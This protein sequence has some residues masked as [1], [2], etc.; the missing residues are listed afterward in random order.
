MSSEADVA[1][2]R[3]RLESM[4]IQH[5]LLQQHNLKLESD[6]QAKQELDHKRFLIEAARKRKEDEENRKRGVE[7]KKKR[8]R[9][10]MNARKNA[11][12][13]EQRSPRYRPAHSNYVPSSKTGV[14]KTG[15]N[16]RVRYSNFPREQRFA[17]QRS[18]DTIP[19]PSDYNPN[20]SNPMEQYAYVDYVRPYANNEQLEAQREQQQKPG[21]LKIQDKKT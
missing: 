17:W 19:G 6:V 7:W 16:A 13:F 2:A 3:A 14:P 11:V 5:R 15:S 20:Y 8:Y 21:I 9:D 4:Q 1:A 18:K 10:R 12:K